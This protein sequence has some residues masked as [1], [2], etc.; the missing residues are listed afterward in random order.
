MPTM[1]IKSCVRRPHQISANNMLKHFIKYVKNPSKLRAFMNTNPTNKEM[2]DFK[3]KWPKATMK[4][5]STI[6]FKILISLTKSL[7]VQKEYIQKGKAE[8]RI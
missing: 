2:E 1:I 8:G 5:L 4:K 7:S 6:H 3:N